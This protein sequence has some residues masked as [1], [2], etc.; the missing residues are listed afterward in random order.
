MTKNEA[1]NQALQRHFKGLTDEK[2]LHG[3]RY[4]VALCR[5]IAAEGCVGVTEEFVDLQSVTKLFAAVAVL[6]LQEQGKLTLSDPVARF[7]PE[8]REEPFANITILHLLT[9]TSG[10]AALQDA[11]P[12]RDMD[13]EAEVDRE[14]IKESWIPAIL[15][16]GLFF[17]PGTKWEYS[18][19]GFCMLGEVIERVTGRKAEDY[20]SEHILLPCGMV[21]SYWDP[22]MDP[23][24][25]VI[26][27]TTWGL[28]APIEELVQFGT[29]LA[30]GGVYCGRRVL[31][32][33]SIELLETNILPADMR[34]YCWDHGGRRVAYGAG[35]PIYITG[36][37]PWWTVGE[38]SIY[39]EGAG[40]CMLLVNRKER[41]AAAWDVPFMDRSCW[42]E[43]AVK[44]TASVIWEYR[45]K[46]TL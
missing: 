26:P 19:A 34:D 17:E 11:F 9:H 4:R 31:S 21:K 28:L 22:D 7:L 29:M 45:K 43:E 44:G 14:R 38:G 25:N 23:I 2:R 18:K 37:E 40:A 8:F 27:R 6:Q 30:E 41:L 5:T 20:I 36:Y 42:C 3:A 1:L 10:L 15:K 16:K 33:G 13:W 39:H 12:E 24:W 35:C 32:E 46:E